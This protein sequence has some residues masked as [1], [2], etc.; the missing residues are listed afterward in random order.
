MK[1]LT[2]ISGGDVGG[3]KT[4][5]LGLLRELS[6]TDAV[7]MVC[8]MEADFTR[9]AQALGIDTRV[10]PGRNL[11]AVLG[12]LTAL[13]REGGYDL[14]H[15]HGSRGN[16]MAWLLRK[17]VKLPLLSTV[18]SDA[19]L[20]YMGRPLAG[21]VYGTLNRMALRRMDYLTGVSDAMTEL[22]IRRGFDPDRIY[23]IYNGVE[24]R[25]SVV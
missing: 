15:S 11:P 25:K 23:T 17:R 12:Q 19:R 5:V 18:H 9:E 2:L 7:T 20:D 6:R 1:I 22:L 10:Y 24:D 21:L 3:A 4:H 16:F 14:L 8:F 13:I